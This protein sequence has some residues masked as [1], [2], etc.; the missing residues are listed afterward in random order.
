MSVYEFSI[1]DLAPGHDLNL[2]LTREL[3]NQKIMEPIMEEKVEY[4]INEALD[5]A[6]C[7]PEEIKEIL[8]TGGSSRIPYVK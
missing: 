6:V 3:F 2:S 4:E 1:P 5:D 7:G 8:L